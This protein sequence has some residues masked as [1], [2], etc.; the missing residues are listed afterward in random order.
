M[1][2]PIISITASSLDVT[3]PTLPYDCGVGGKTSSTLII[4]LSQ[5]GGKFLAQPAMFRPSIATSSSSSSS[6][7]ALIE[8]NMPTAAAAAAA[9]CPRIQK[10]TPLFMSPQ[11]LKFA[12]FE[13]MAEQLGKLY[14][15]TCGDGYLSGDELF[16][17]LQRKARVLADGD[18]ADDNNNIA[19]ADEPMLLYQK[20]PIHLLAGGSYFGSFSTQLAYVAHLVAPSMPEVL[21]LGPGS[22][23]AGDELKIR[24][25]GDA[26]FRSSKLYAGNKLDVEAGG[27][28]TRE[29]L[30]HT[31]T[32][33]DVTET[34][35]AA[36]EQMCC[37]SDAGGGG[38]DQLRVVGHQ[39]YSEKGSITLGLGETDVIK[40]ST[41]GPVDIQP[42]VEKR[43]EVSKHKSGDIFGE[44]ESQIVRTVH[45]ILP[46]VSMAGRDHTILAGKDQ[47]IHMAGHHVAAK[48]DV[49]LTA[50]G[51]SRLEADGVA[52]V[53]TVDSLVSS[54]SGLAGAIT[55]GSDVDARTHQETLQVVKGSIEAGRDLVLD[56][57]TADFRGVDARWSRVL[58]DQT[59][60]LSIGPL[61]CETIQS[62]AYSTD[63]RGLLLP[64]NQS[65]D[66]SSTTEEHHV[67]PSS[68]NGPRAEFVPT[69]DHKGDLSDKPTLTLTSTHLSVEETKL[70]K[71][72]VQKVAKAW[73]RKRETVQTDG[74]S[75]ISLDAFKPPQLG[76]DYIQNATHLGQFVNTAFKT[77]RA[78]GGSNPMNFAQMVSTATLTSFQGESSLF[79]SADVPNDVS[80]GDLEIPGPVKIHLQGFNTVRNLFRQG[81]VVQLESLSAAPMEQVLIYDSRVGS[82]SLAINPFSLSYSSAEQQA[83]MRLMRRQFLNSR[84]SLL[85]FAGGDGDDHYQPM[86]IIN[87]SFHA[88]GLHLT[89]PQATGSKLVLRVDG[90][91]FGT[92]CLDT[93][94]LEESSSA[95]HFG[96]SLGPLLACPAG[97]VGLL[98]SATSTLGMME[99]FLSPEEHAKHF[100]SAS[101]S[102]PQ[103]PAGIFADVQLTVGG[104][105]ICRDFS[106]P[107]STIV[108]TEE[109][110]PTFHSSWETHDCTPATLMSALQGAIAIGNLVCTGIELG[111]NFTRLAHT[112]PAQTAREDESSE[113]PE[114]EKVSK[115]EKT[116]QTR[117]V[118]I[119]PSVKKEKTEKKK[120]PRERLMFIEHELQKL[121]PAVAAAAES[122]EADLMAL[123]AS[124][125]SSKIKAIHEL[126][127]TN[128]E[129]SEHG[130]KELWLETLRDMRNNPEDYI[131][132][133][134]RFVL[135]FSSLLEKLIEGKPITVK[136]VVVDAAVEAAWSAG[137]AVKPV[138]RGASRMLGKAGEEL[139][140]LFSRKCLSTADVKENK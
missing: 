29:T 140:D 60:H 75:L 43:V 21:L 97:M 101:L 105:S 94:L 96:L 132:D 23:H 129:S 67:I 76:Q 8:L 81:G 124:N 19:A 71:N 34:K 3:N 103:H 88:A 87:G 16:E 138:Y 58:R 11:V 115:D 46:S 12:L 74:W 122:T 89:V 110:L 127:V 83:S 31:W 37:G 93:L 49:I 100:S 69:E 113:A 59:Q 18:D 57:Q 68:W 131:R 120:L 5:Y 117:A 35:A 66:I 134:I 95:E 70:E 102:D 137:H 62:F 64:S 90:D 130:V 133:G 27:K 109:K 54:S 63:S 112:E 99:S 111:E 65:V 38:G 123:D 33:E 106:L 86:L 28:L 2:A 36:R 15:P 82:N 72:V 32:S 24:T 48:R 135:P 84:L 42:V 139:V 22:M 126:V 56:T 119:S 53:D 108:D 4:D 6:S 41:E 136:E 91:F 107:R 121:F 80:W 47:T 73:V 9:Y 77:G 52:V 116:Q 78:L 98:S 125:K 13:A 92:A 61:E 1:S 128:I 118:H 51:R 79:C 14:L 10:E 50:P 20:R 55:G 40:G 7:K 114:E 26:T 45:T 25:S 17:E 30:L 104:R 44:D 39:G 85:G